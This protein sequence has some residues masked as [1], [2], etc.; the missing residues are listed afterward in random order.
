M[1]RDYALFKE[2]S[3]FLRIRDAFT[4]SN[5]RTPIPGNTKHYHFLNYILPL[6]RALAKRL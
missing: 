6:F 4:I 5:H 1:F 3:A 2:L